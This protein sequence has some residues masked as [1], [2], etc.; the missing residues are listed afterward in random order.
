MSTY[1][2]LIRFNRDGVATGAHQIDWNEDGSKT[3]PAAIDPAVIGDVDLSATIADRDALA[4]KVESLEA[5]IADLESQIDAV[6]QGA[7][8]RRMISVA[9]WRSR[10]TDD[11]KAALAASTDETLITGV[12]TANQ[13]H[14]AKRLM[15]LDH[16][17]TLATVDRMV[18]L[19]IFTAERKT[20]LLRDSVAAERKI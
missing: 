4:A 6:V 18:A 2:I 15:D 3:K 9:A 19:E 13:V 10:F 14:A 16:A 12:S 20:E 17:I 8:S 1:E 5:T 11:E 7:G